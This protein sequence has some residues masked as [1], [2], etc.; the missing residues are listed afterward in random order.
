MITRRLCLLRPVPFFLCVWLTGA[1]NAGLIGQGNASGRPVLTHP[2]DQS[3][4]LTDRYAYPGTVLSQNPVG[5]WRLENDGQTTVTD[6]AA[7]PYP[8]ASR[9]SIT[10]GVAG[11]LGDG[12]TAMQFDGV[13]GTFIKMAEDPAVNLSTALTVEGWAKATT[14]TGTGLVLNRQVDK[15]GI[16]YRLLQDGGNWI[17]HVEGPMGATE[18]SVP[19][20]LAD[21]GTW[22]YLVGTFDGAAIRL[23]RNGVLAGTVAAPSA[24]WSGTGAAWIGQYFA[25]A[26]DEIAVYPTALTA[27]Q[28]ANHYALRTATNSVRLQLSATNPKNFGLTYAATGLPPGLTLNAATGLISGDPTVAGTFT[29]TVTVRHSAGQYDSQVFTWTV[30]LPPLRSPHAPVLTHP[31]DQTN[32]VTDRYGYADTVLSQYPVGY[33]RLDHDGQA[34]VTDWAATPYPGTSSGRITRGVPG[35]LSDGSAA[36]QFDGVSGTFIKMA[37]DPAVNLST[38]LTVEGWAKATTQTSTGLVLNRQVDNAGIAYRLMQSGGSWVF[39]VE[40]PMGATEVSVPVDLA[41]VGSWT[42][43]VGTF[44]GAA[45]RLYRNGVLA[46]TAAQPYALWSGTGPAWIGQS[47]VGALDEI[48]VYPLAL[49]AAQIANHYA[50]RTATASVSLVLVATDVDRDVLTY[51]ATGLPP[52][53]ELNPATG[54]ITGN[55]R[56]AGAY[57]VTV[58]VT[59]P[60]G[61]TSTRTFVWTITTPALPNPH[62]PVLANPG[63]RTNATTESVSLMLSATDVD[64][65]ALTYGAAGLPPGLSLNPTTGAITGTPGVAGTY[66]VTVTVTD[67]A[68]LT[69]TRTFVWTITTPVLVNPHAPVL[70]NPADQTTPVKAPYGYP[71][72]VL[73]DQAAGYWRLDVDGRVNVTDWAA[74]PHPGTGSGGIT[75]GVAGALSN[76]STAMQFDGATGTAIAIA[77]NPALNV[78]T[79][80]TVEG[81]AKPTTQTGT[82]V[83]LNRQVDNAGSAYQ[84]LQQGG[85]W[86]FRVGRGAA[87]RRPRR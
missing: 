41:D 86:V 29:V 38:A 27:A 73:A 50:L 2:G 10:R 80:L 43:L 39:H 30:T 59:D 42:Y 13:S 74:T 7:I 46:G 64:Q 61:L 57:T 28:I 36:M 51:S 31:G 83:L 76:L 23:Y 37:A 52:G 17:F 12:S 22:T 56:V 32:P 70:T 60:A 67:P 58:T 82:G 11:A 24:L 69:S 71:Q 1:A 48:A 3:N 4:P 9:G 19:I 85:N 65:D 66:T 79:A 54:V 72:T 6:A 62:A 68:G 16:A 8:G 18:V 78:S 40:G 55:P 33:W 5:Y 15:A 77:S 53:L 75:Q 87:T 20:D 63:D 14:Q 81:W 45:V 25:G 84:L 21:V 44:D 47:F 34:T 35:A 26:L 49:T